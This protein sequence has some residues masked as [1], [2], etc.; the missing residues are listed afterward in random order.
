MRL[1]RVVD[2]GPIT[3]QLLWYSVGRIS[4]F[5]LHNE[6]DDAICLVEIKDLLKNSFV[7][8]MMSGRLALVLR[9]NNHSGYLMAS[10][11]E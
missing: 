5:G 3:L 2:S 1:Y 11:V 9:Y 4:E 10:F 6:V 8:L 7:P